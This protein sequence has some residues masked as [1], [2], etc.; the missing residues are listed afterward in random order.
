MAIIEC[1]ECKKEVSDQAVS[2]PHCGYGIKDHF[3]KIEYEKRKLEQEEMNKHK[4]E[5]FK[6]FT[7]PKIKLIAKISAIIIVAALIISF[8]HYQNKYSDN[9]LKLIHPDTNTIDLFFTYGFPKNGN[10][11][12]KVQCNTIIGTLTR[13][14]DEYKWETNCD[15]I[16]DLDIDYGYIQRGFYDVPIDY[17]AENEIRFSNDEYYYVLKRNK[18]NLTV[19]INIVPKSKKWSRM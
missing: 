13:D 19:T 1:P 10:T 18:H 9:F 4:I 12:T 7:L 2:C 8:I 16:E 5:L 14:E 6:R 11:W 3:A 17:E 15:D